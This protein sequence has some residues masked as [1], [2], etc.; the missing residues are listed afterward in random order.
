MKWTGHWRTSLRRLDPRTHRDWRWFTIAVL[1]GLV[2]RLIWV[3]WATKTP[4]EPYSD[5]ARY[6]DMAVRF[7]GLST[8][9]INGHTTAFT[10]PAYSALLAP[11][12]FV[13]RH[14][15]WFGLPMAASLI[16]VLAGTFTVAAVGLLTARWF[17]RAAGITAAWMMALF[18][19]HLYLTSVALTETLFAAL[20]VGF[21][22]FATIL[23]QGRW[24]TC[25]VW[26]WIGLGLVVG[27]ATL[28]RFPGALLVV[29][30][31]LAI[32]GTT[33][34]WRGS[35]RVTAWV[36][37]A[38]GLSL[39]PWTVR[40][41]IEVGV[42][43]PTS[44]NSA[45]FICSGHY[46]GSEG[47]IPYDGPPR[48]YQ[49]SPFD[50]E[51]DEARWYRDTTR[52]TISWTVTHPVDTAKITLRVAYEMMRDDRDALDAA[53]D[54]NRQRLVGE[55]GATALD[56]LATFWHLGVLL[57]ALAGLL[58]V[59]A[60]RKALPV[61]AVALAIFATG[62]AGVGITRLHTMFQPLLVC[63]AAAALVAMREGGRTFPER[64]HD[65]PV[66]IDA[67]ETGS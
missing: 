30:P 23:A 32:R 63:L 16:N 20:T 27:Y 35:L 17:D 14:T 5:T 12:A 31:A 57:L 39:V 36:A 44:T 6:L 48:C 9:T 7:S 50:T 11:F 46:P 40:N 8:E 19:A 59:G 37:L 47:A 34:S 53:Q 33:G 62:L 56:W 13:S 3:I 65:E 67:A 55:F 15:G 28:V 64:T 60:C 58:L 2:L 41:G 25:S 21:L 10:P 29:V 18:P 22:L 66:P 24:K 42:W 54:F 52:D 1:V 26:V 38:A 51:V 43:T 49:N 45:A 61:W 4:L